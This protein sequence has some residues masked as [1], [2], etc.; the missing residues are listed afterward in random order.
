M[1]IHE[2]NHPRSFI[3]FDPL[4]EAHTMDNNQYIYKN[5]FKGLTKSK[6]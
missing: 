4:R 1:N 3:D 2:D 5:K 6:K